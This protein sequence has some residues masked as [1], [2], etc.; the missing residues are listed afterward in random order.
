MWF[1]SNASAALSGLAVQCPGDHVHSAWGK[2]SGQELRTAA[3]ELPPDLIAKIVSNLARVLRVPPAAVRL[4][5]KSAALTASD[6]AAEGVSAGK[7]L[8]GAKARP[9]LPEFSRVISADLRE[10]PTWLLRCIGK[11][12]PEAVLTDHGV[13][14]KGSRLISAVTEDGEAGAASPPR[15]HCLVCKSLP[16]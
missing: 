4:A 5:A 16:S 6:L 15:L 7:Q 8:R 9:V 1:A 2:L 13:A 10:P 12:M 3:L 14:P 11:D